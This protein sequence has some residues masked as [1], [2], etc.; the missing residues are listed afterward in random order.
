MEGKAKYNNGRT[1][2]GKFVNGMRQD[3]DASLTLSH[4][5][6]FKGSFRDDC[7]EKGSYTMAADG[8]RFEG[9]YKNNIPHTG[10]WYNSA[11]QPESQIENGKELHKEQG[12]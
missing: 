3:D 5:D 1:Y 6:T 7:Y 8:Y 4:G 10:I 9:T 12:E 11:G 2:E